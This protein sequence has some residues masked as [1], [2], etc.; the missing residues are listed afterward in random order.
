[1]IALPPVSS[2]ARL[3]KLRRVNR[4][5]RR[6]NRDPETG[7]T[8]AGKGNRWTSLQEALFSGWAPAKDGDVISIAIP[9]F[10]SLNSQRCKKGTQ[11]V[12]DCLHKTSIC[13]ICSSTIGGRTG[14]DSSFE[15]RA[16][17]RGWFVGLVKNRTKQNKRR[18]RRSSSRGLIDRDVS[19][20]TPA[21]AGNVDSR[22]ASRRS[23]RA[24]FVNRFRG[25]SGAGSVPVQ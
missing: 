15:A 7:C 11:N 20:V 1:M 6:K 3:L 9:D 5:A 2:L 4:G 8:V 18:S 10:S 13:G 21:S 16:A 22:V 12:Q 14:F 23:D 19:E 17:C 25:R 24:G